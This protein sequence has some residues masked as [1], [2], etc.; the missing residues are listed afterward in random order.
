MFGPPGFT[1]P[2]VLEFGE[3]EQMMERMNKSWEE[4]KIEEKEFGENFLDDQG[5]YNY[6]YGPNTEILRQEAVKILQNQGFL[7]DQDEHYTYFYHAKMY[8]T[9]R[10]RNDYDWHIGDGCLMDH[11]VVSVMFFV[12]KDP[13][14]WGGNLFWNPNGKIEEKGK[15]LINIETGTVVIIPGDTPHMIECISH[16][17]GRFIGRRPVQEWKLIEFQFPDLRRRIVVDEGVD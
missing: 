7:V 6:N 1:P 10:P 14:L 16:W 8:H 15:K 5:D 4:N 12:E 13:L 9:E 2:T 17:N 11:K 3:D